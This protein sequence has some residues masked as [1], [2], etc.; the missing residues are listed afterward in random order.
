MHII[1]K[2]I[3]ECEQSGLTQAMFQKC[4]ETLYEVKFPAIIVFLLKSIVKITVQKSGPFANL[5]MI[6]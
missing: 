3:M 2:I 6:L 4:I 5:K 1:G